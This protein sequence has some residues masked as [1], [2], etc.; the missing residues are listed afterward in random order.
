[1]IGVRF[2]PIVA[3]SVGLLFFRYVLPIVPFL[4]LTAAYV[5]ART[6]ET[7]KARLGESSASFLRMPQQ[8]RRRGR[9]L[10]RDYCGSPVF[11]MARAITPDSSARLMKM[12]WLMMPEP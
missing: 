5:V 2:P 9:L 11:S 12:S 8:R 1:M 10:S 7:E 6:L 4:C 3:G